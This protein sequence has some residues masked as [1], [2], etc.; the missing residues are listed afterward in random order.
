[1]AFCSWRSAYSTRQPAA[2]QALD[3][4]C[5]TESFAHQALLRYAEAGSSPPVTDAAT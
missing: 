5:P 3:W 1:M 2:S 4:T